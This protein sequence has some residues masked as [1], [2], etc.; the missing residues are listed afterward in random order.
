[1][2]HVAL[3][4]IMGALGKTVRAPGAILRVPGRNWERFPC[5]YCS[6]WEPWEELGGNRAWMRLQ[7]A[8][9]GARAKGVVMQI[10]ERSRAVIGGWEQR[11]VTSVT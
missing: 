10:Q 2:P 4:V 3:G 8:G 7:P 5:Q 9:G 1:M 11:G 6:Y